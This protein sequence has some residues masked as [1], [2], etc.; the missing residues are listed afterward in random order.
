MFVW[1][2]PGPIVLT[3]MPLP[4]TR[5]RLGYR[6][7]TTARG[8]SSGL[9][10]LLAV[11]A[12]K[13]TTVGG[14]D[15][16]EVLILPSPLLP[17]AVY[18]GLA[19]ALKSRG[20]AAVV[21]DASLRDGQG[22]Q[23]LVARWVAMAGPD[24]CLLA[25]SNAGFLVPVVRARLSTV[26]AIVFMDAALLPPEGGTELAPDRFL[27]HLTGLAGP[28]GALPPWTRWWSREDML[29]VI[30]AADYEDIDHECPRLPLSY[31]QARVTAPSEWATQPNAYLAFGGTYDE[32][33]CFAMAH[34]WPHRRLDGQHLHFL[35]DPDAVA[36]SVIELASSLR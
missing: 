31:F 30:P 33:L 12:A 29:E 23:D 19:A 5:G 21:G 36:S 28:D 7:P 6:R 35:K 32:E 4:A 14:V 16:A 13:T 24:S 34:G 3:V 17:S 11:R 9:H 18:G 10:S 25:H 20:H 27:Q 26:Q 22:R 2:T 8:T 1:M 15:D